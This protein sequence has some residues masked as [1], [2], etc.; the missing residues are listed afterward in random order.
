MRSNLRITLSAG[1]ILLAFLFSLSN[2]TCSSDPVSSG[3]GGS[4]AT[5]QWSIIS[6]YPTAATI[7]GVT[8]SN[9]KTCWAVGGLGV[10]LKSP[11]A[12]DTW[13]TVDI[14]CRT[15]LFDIAFA[16]SRHGWAVGDDGLILHTSDGGR[17]WSRQESSVTARLFGVACISG[18]SVWAVGQGVVLETKDGG[19]SWLLRNDLPRD[20]YRDVNFTSPD[21][22]CVVGGNTIL[23]T[24][25]SGRSWTEFTF[26]ADTLDFVELEAVDFFGHDSGIAVGTYVRWGSMEGCRAIT[27]DGGRTWSEQHTRLMLGSVN[28][29]RDGAIIAMCLASYVQRSFDWGQT[30][31]EYPVG[32]NSVYASAIS[33]GGVIL[34]GGY[35]GRV[36]RSADN[37]VT[38]SEI[39]SGRRPIT[40]TDL[41]FLTESHGF[42]TQFTGDMLETWDGGYTWQSTDIVGSGAVIDF[43][44]DRWGWA[45]SRGGNLYRT[46][47]GGTTWELAR[48]ATQRL[49][50]DIDM[51]DSLTGWN[52]GFPAIM[53]T[54]DGGEVWVVKFVSDFTLNAICSL[55]SLTVWAFGNFGTILFTTDG[56]TWHRV[57]SGTTEYLFDAQ[58]LD[59]SEAWCVGNSGTVLHTIDAGETWNPV[60]IGTTLDLSQVQFIDHERG[61]IGSAG[62]AVF[63]TTD[64]GTTW[65]EQRTAGRHSIQALFMLDENTGW[66]GGEGGEIMR[67]EP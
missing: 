17:T 56:D 32:T 62:G 50:L 7:Y 66:T 18:T 30:W 4:S 14:D 60:N 54:E 20:W 5:E 39:S 42:Q 37:G 3:G 47:D 45:S 15:T 57:E 28:V 59:D 44:N 49:L 51:V 67:L 53:H 2:L 61:W 25:D 1:L 35:R 63:S 31:E 6:P 34:A 21:H 29:S 12:G 33:P 22:G 19:H 58:F 23:T 26:S 9:D 55:D 10:I 24:F 46:Y 52:C 16:D 11:D 40:I 65:T 41:Y 27:T 48:P 38:W 43:V 13:S 8:F 64:G 36:A